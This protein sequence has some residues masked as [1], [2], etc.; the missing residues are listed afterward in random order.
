MIN[1][2][3]EVQ[4]R[5]FI[6]AHIK[7]DSIKIPDATPEIIQFCMD[8]AKPYG[9]VFEHEST[10]ERMCLVNESTY[11]AKYKDG[12]FA[13]EWSATGLEFQVPYIF[14]SMF[15]KEPI[16]FGDM[17][18]TMSVKTALY[19]DMNDNLPDTIDLENVKLIR[20]D[21]AL[22]GIANI[23]KK[24]LEL[25]N[26]WSHLSDLELD[27]R[28]AEGHN[29]RFIGKVGRFCPIKPGCGGG[30]LL[31]Q[32]IDKNGNVKYNAATGSKGYRW[33]ESEMVQELGKEKDIDLSYY[34]KQVEDAKA[35]ISKYGDFNWF[36]SDTPY[37]TPPYL[38]GKPIYVPWK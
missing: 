27:A 33:L 9:Y 34:D 5:G 37:E 3:H 15:T 14:K 25:Y 2:K 32:S 6:V 17:C 13:G 1:L 16:V 23:S 38:D 11:I 4:D 8:Y 22:N 21:I 28:I 19:L 10:Y 24:W 12:E 20:L 36:V 31:R 35:S 18:E 7:T 26:S 29:H 30:V